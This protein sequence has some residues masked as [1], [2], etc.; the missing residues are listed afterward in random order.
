MALCI[1]AA[2]FWE[3]QCHTDPLP[4]LEAWWLSRTRRSCRSTSPKRSK[5]ILG[6]DPCHSPTS[7]RAGVGTISLQHCCRAARCKR[8]KAGPVAGP[9]AITTSRVP[10][11]RGDTNAAETVDGPLFSRRRRSNP[12]LVVRFPKLQTEGP[13]RGRPK[14]EFGGPARR[15]SRARHDRT[16]NTAKARAPVTRVTGSGPANR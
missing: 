3:S 14:Y 7:P 9:D 6:P 12:Q 5:R 10:G 8:G 13:A 15:E 11:R 1:W 2:W 4:P 16:T